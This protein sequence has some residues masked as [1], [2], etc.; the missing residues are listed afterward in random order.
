MHSALAERLK[1]KFNQEEM[2]EEFSIYCQQPFLVLTATCTARELDQAN[3][4]SLLLNKRLR[5]KC[6]VIKNFFI[7]ITMLSLV[8]IAI[9]NYRIIS[10]KT[11]I[12]HLLLS[13]EVDMKALNKNHFSLEVVKEQLSQSQPEYPQDK[14]M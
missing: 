1:D 4:N 5:I 8:S 13:V 7:K 3:N 6:L 12:L 14:V 11:L 9:E 10:T 2:K